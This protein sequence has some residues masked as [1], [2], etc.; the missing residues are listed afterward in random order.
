MRLPVLIL[1]ALTAFGQ[2]D[3][4]PIAFDAA[5]IKPFPEGQPI[6]FSGCQGGPGGGDPGRI[7][8]QYMTLKMLVTRAYQMKSQEVFGP[9]WMEEAHYNVLAK[10]PAGATKDQVALMFRNLLAERFHLVSHKEKRQL[11][12]Y[13]LTVAKGGV[14]FQ[15]SAPQAAN[16]E[17]PAPSGPPKRGE[18]GFPVLSPSVYRGGPII[19]F[20]NGKARLLAGDTTVA[21]LAESFS[22][23]LDRVVVDESGLTGRYDFRLDWTPDASEPGGSRRSEATAPEPDV[24]V[25]LEQ[26]L[27][28]KAVQKKVERD[29]LVVDSADRTPTGN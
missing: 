17:D 28:L 25:A 7:D 5:S 6:Q 27:G 22:S 24:F 16:A 11:P 20:R 18:D 15:E 23:Q 3:D 29:A 21:R 9:K 4:A 10:V 2:S 19:L 13:A 12:V 14:K 1:L 8:C 26:Q